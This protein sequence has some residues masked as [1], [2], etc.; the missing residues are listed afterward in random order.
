MVYNQVKSSQVKPTETVVPVCL[1]VDVLCFVAVN[2]AVSLSLCVCA[3]LCTM[4]VVF[5]KHDNTRQQHGKNT[6][7]QHIN[8]NNHSDPTNAWSPKETRQSFRQN[9]SFPK[10]RTLSVCLSVYIPFLSCLCLNQSVTSKTQQS[11]LELAFGTNKHLDIS[12]APPATKRLTDRPEQTRF[13]FWQPE[14]TQRMGQIVD[15]REN[16][17]S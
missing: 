8:D 12:R 7:H 5:H 11:R 15:A 6:A 1:L 17:L 16:G 2:V 13:T 10:T 14:T 4:H 9:D 3:F